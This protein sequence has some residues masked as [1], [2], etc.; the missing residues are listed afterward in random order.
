[1]FDR[2]LAEW[3]QTNG[4]TS[5][6]D[7]RELRKG[8]KLAPDFPQR[9]VDIILGHTAWRCGGRLEQG[10]RECVEGKAQDNKRQPFDSQHCPSRCSPETTRA[11]SLCRA[12]CA[13]C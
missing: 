4:G 11:K 8:V 12:G 2:R 7:G 3:K 6:R 5:F 1:M 9:D 13:N 10:I